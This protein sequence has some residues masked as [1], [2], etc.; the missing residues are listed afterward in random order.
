MRVKVLDNTTS[1]YSQDIEI[2]QGEGTFA[3][4]AVLSD[5]DVVTLQV[6]IPLSLAI[7]KE[8]IAKKSYEFPK[9]CL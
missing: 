4:P 1:I 3:V 8:I 9:R 2:S 6:N 5:S 7:F